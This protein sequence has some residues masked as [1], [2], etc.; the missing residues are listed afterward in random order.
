MAEGIPVAKVGEIGD[1]EAIV[2]PRI[3][4]GTYD[5]IAVFNS[6]GE[7]F[8]LDDT[9]SHEEASLADGWIE[10]GTVECPLHA[11]R[12]CLKDGEA[13]SLPATSG[14]AV[15]EVVVDGDDILVIP[16]PERIA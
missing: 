13:M 14:V 15:H 4:T 6:G 10:D 3:R 5:D 1:D 9:C 11:A 2:V 7:Y 16:N 8:A 12:F